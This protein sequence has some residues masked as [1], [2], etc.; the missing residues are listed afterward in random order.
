MSAISANT[1]YS[2]GL[3]IG[4][5]TA[6]L[7]I[8]TEENELV[9]SAYERHLSEPRV[10]LTRL[11]AAAARELRRLRL[12]RRLDLRGRRR[13]RCRVL[14]RTDAKSAHGRPAHVVRFV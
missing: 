2:L 12:I 11:L 6:K 4:S 9:F 10:V 13:V 1:G 3:D 14:T 7:V 8:L 5:T